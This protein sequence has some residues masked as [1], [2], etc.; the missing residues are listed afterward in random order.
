MIGLL[1]VFNVGEKIRI[2]SENDGGYVVPTIAI[3]DSKSLF[4]YGIA[5]DITFDE[6]YIEIKNLESNVYGF[7][8]TIDSVPTKY[9][10]NFILHKEGISAHK[11]PC[12]DNFLQHYQNLGL[13]DKCFL[14]IDVEGDEYDFFEQTNIS[15]IDKRATGMVIEFHSIKEDNFRNRFWN[16]IERLN[17]HFLICHIHGNNHDDIYHYQDERISCILPSVLEITFISKQIVQDFKPDESIYPSELDNRN[18]KDKEDFDL[19]YL[20]RL[21][22]I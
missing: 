1:K 3:E 21:H 11:T 4:S 15:E 13:T 7:D 17:E 12:T 8:H 19:S 14:K 6:H 10:N 9:V 18:K 22:S 20:S 5:D 16:I 2:G